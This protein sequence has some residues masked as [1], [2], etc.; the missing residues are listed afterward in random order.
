[1]L[2]HSPQLPVL[3]DRLAEQLAQERITRDRFCDEMTPDQKT[4]FIDGEVIVHSPAKT[5]SSMQQHERLSNTC[6]SKRN[7]SC[8]SSHHRDAFAAS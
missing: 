5:G 2:L 4:E 3:V 7:T 6:L 1:M 8:E